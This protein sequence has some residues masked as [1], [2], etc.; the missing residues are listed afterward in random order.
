[1]TFLIA[2]T[3]YVTKLGSRQDVVHCDEGSLA[4]RVTLAGEAGAWG[5]WS[6]GGKDKGNMTSPNHL[7][8]ATGE[9]A[10]LG[11]MRMEEVALPLAKSS[12]LESGPCN[13]SGQN[14]RADRP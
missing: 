5:G 13:S 11:G 14:G 12:S 10:S 7:P 6:R 1:M 9:R 8:S 3:E 2:M 4:S